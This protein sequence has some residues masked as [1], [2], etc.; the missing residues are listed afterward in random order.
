[1]KPTAWALI[2]VR[3]VFVVCQVL[4]PV[5]GWFTPAFIVRG[6]AAAFILCDVSCRDE[7]LAWEMFWLTYSRVL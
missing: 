2:L 1:M 6:T 5:D 7:R 4:L 3:A